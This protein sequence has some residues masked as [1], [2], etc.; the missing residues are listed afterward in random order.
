[1]QDAKK[2][3]DY[4]IA[5]MKNSMGDMG[6]YWRDVKEHFK[7]LKPTPEQIRREKQYQERNKKRIEKLE[8]FLETN[9]ISVQKFPQ[10]G[11]WNLGNTIDW[12][13]TTGT[14]IARKSRNKY[15]FTNKNPEAILE[16][17]KKET[18]C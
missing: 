6:D 11:Q 2:A 5:I 17:I 7:N 1:M 8:S 13:T 16:A 14:A 10:T 18:P 3:N 9:N 15:R 12:W 4:Y